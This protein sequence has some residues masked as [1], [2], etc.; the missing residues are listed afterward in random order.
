MS[1]FA[2]LTTILSAMLK[3][4]NKIKAIDITHKIKKSKENILR[5]RERERER[6][7]EKVIL[8]FF[9]VGIY[10]VDEAK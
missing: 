7:V 6:A 4:L 2:Q 8:T 9:C 10:K 3:S 1:A 5:E